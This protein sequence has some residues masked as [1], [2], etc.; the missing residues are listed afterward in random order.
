[1]WGSLRVSQVMDKSHFLDW[2]EAQIDSAP[3]FETQPHV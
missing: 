2:F 3:R 1:V